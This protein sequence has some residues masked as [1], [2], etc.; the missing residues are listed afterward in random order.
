MAVRKMSVAGVSIDVH[1]RYNQIIQ[2]KNVQFWLELGKYPG[3]MTAFV[4]VVVVVGGGVSSI[5]VLAWHASQLSVV[6][7]SL[8]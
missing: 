3:Q 4:V 1:G 8:D 6:C 2:A 7:G 5:A